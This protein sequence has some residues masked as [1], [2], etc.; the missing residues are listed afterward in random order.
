MLDTLNINDIS[1]HDI[2]K[3]IIKI[4]RTLTKFEHNRNNQ[5]QK[6]SNSFYELY[7]NLYDSHKN[8]VGENETLNSMRGDSR[9]TKILDTTGE[10]NLL[11][12]GSAFEIVKDRQ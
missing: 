8:V 11:T 7:I 2:I 9:R 4:H 5:T 3:K 1:N 10:S 12:L 6:M